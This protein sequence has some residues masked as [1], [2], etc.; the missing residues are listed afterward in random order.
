MS[1]AINKSEYMHSHFQYIENKPYPKV[2]T[3]FLP[4]KGAERLEAP[5]GMLINNGFRLL[6]MMEMKKYRAIMKF[7]TI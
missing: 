1:E 5:R 2:Y 3:L 7:I 6:D 4:S